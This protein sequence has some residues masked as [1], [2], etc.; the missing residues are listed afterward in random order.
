MNQSPDVSQ[1]PAFNNGYG[2]LEGQALSAGR[3]AT[4]ADWLKHVEKGIL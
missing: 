3:A 2:F 4:L 1:C